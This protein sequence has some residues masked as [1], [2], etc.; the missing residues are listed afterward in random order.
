MKS[1]AEAYGIPIDSR[2]ISLNGTYWGLTEPECIA[3]IREF[4]SFISNTF[5]SETICLWKLDEKTLKNPVDFQSSSAFRMDRCF[6]EMMGDFPSSM[7]FNKTSL[8]AYERK[9]GMDMIFHTNR[10]PAFASIDYPEY[11]KQHL[12]PYLND[13]TKYKKALSDLFSLENRVN[14]QQNIVHDIDFCFVNVHSNCVTSEFAGYFDL[15]LSCYAIENQLDHFGKAFSGLAKYISQKFGNLNITICIEQQRFDY[16]SYCVGNLT[17]NNEENMTQNYRTFL[18]NM[19][20]YF[21]VQ[22]AG[23]V[24]ILSPKLTEHLLR[25]HATHTG[26]IKVEIFENDSSCLSIDKNLSS[27]CLQD[28]K[29]MKQM[30]YPVLLP[31]KSVFSIQREF[32][33]YWQNAP[34]LDSEIQVCESKVYFK[35]GQ[36]VD[37]SLYPNDWTGW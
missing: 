7:V 22:N 4:I 3:L 29:H 12:L 23:W 33:N 34:M 8:R 31:G 25:D 32:R 13:P 27:V 19:A 20:K 24:N 28:L 36:P 35:Q 5:P 18:E 2:R 1:M 11:R 26:D 15:S 17:F 10:Y 21:Y 30:I 37:E 16:L 6:L 14:T 9:L